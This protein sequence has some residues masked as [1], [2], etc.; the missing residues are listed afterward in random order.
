[1]GSFKDISEAESESTAI[2]AKVAKSTIRSARAH[3][4]PVIE[5][6][7]FNKVV[8]WGDDFSEDRIKI[9]CMP[10]NCERRRW[11]FS[12]KEWLPGPVFATIK[13]QNPSLVEVVLKATY[14]LVTINIW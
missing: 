7:L 2:G 13:S 8:V 6:L 9:D 4:R 12:C 3:D 10:K 14:V 1:M 11:G 5:L